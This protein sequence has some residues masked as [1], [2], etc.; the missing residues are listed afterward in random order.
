MVDDHP[1]PTTY[2]VWVRLHLPTAAWTRYAAGIV[3]AGKAME[4]LEDVL[5][6]GKGVVGG[7]VLMTGSE[8]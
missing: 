8:P 6:S 3:D 1:E 7:C 4:M 2:T 5:E